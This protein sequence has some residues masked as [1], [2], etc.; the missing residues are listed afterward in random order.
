MWNRIKRWMCSL[1]CEKVKKIENEKALLT[2]L[3]EYA[4]TDGVDL[5]VLKKVSETATTVA[6]REKG[7][8]DTLQVDVLNASLRSWANGEATPRE[9]KSLFRGGR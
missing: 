2:A 5:D 4:L 7:K 6:M 3:A 1:L 9:F 8:L